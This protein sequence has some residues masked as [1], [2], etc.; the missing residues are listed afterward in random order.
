MTDESS[1]QPLPLEERIDFRNRWIAGVLAW[2]IPGAG[3]LYQRRYF[4]AAAYTVCILG[5]FIWGSSMGEAKAVHLRW[6]SGGDA[7]TRHRSLG[8]LAQVG[9]GLPALPAVLQKQRYEEQEESFELQRNAGEIIEEFDV[10]FTGIIRDAIEGDAEVTGMLFGTLQAA[11]FSGQ[12]FVGGF[13]GQT[14]DGRPIELELQGMRRYSSSDTLHIGKRICAL[15]DVTVRNGSEATG[16]L[17]SADRRRF[18]VRTSGKNAGFI[19]GTIPRSVANHYQVP[20]EDAALQY[21]HGRLGKFYE[22]ALVYTWIAGLLNILAVWDCVQG[23]AYGYGDEPDPEI[24]S[25]AHKG[26]SAAETNAAIAA[27]EADGSDTQPVQEKG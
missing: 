22:L 13:R 14:A 9:V 7:K 16:L 25:D 19:E 23:P 5:V 17:F 20:L 24:S 21:I 18:F 27:R 8:Y 15:D 2:L 1:K 3:H 6:D 26:Q 11:E 4:K 12:E 10:E